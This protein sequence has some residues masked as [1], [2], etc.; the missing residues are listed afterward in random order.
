MA[1]SSAKRNERPA[2][3][4][5][6]SPPPAPVSSGRVRIRGGTSNME[7][8]FDLGGRFDRNELTRTE[9][10]RLRNMIDTRGAWP[11]ATELGLAPATLLLAC[12]GFG[13]RLR[14]KTAERL[15]EYLR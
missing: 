10:D 7:E 1:R 6:I 4:A 3:R 15:R 9:I 8:L 14:P 5:A 12:A 13:H 11:V 2:M